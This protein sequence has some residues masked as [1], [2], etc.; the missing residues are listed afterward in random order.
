M[1][2]AGSRAILREVSLRS[3]RR[4]P[5]GRAQSPMGVTQSSPARQAAPRA[6][7][8]ASVPEDVLWAT[9]PSAPFS[10]PFELSAS[11]GRIWIAPANASDGQKQVFYFKGANWVRARQIAKPANAPK[12]TVRTIVQAGFQASGCVHRLW[13]DTVE[14]YIA[15]LV[16]H[17]FNSVRL[18]LS[19]QWILSND[20]TDG[21]C[22][23]Y[24]GWA[25]LDILDDLVIRLEQAGIFV[26]LDMHTLEVDGNQGLWCDPNSRGECTA[27]EEA[28]IRE[29]WEVL[30]A[31]YCSSPN[32]VGADLFNEPY[33]ATWGL[34]SSG[35]DWGLAAGRLGNHVLSHCS[36][37]LI[38]VEGVANNDGQ[39]RAS[40]S[41]D[42]CWCQP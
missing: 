40:A 19:V 10:T 36:R 29:A 28:P 18:P 31:R 20:E 42:F 39:C 17:R 13:D 35:T 5:A 11:E 3:A 27:N 34:G 7:R 8:A 25:T 16:E 33:S 41:H 4:S 32:V 6:I 1:Q 21:L 12:P 37:W 23:E 15:F 2:S 26:V 38:L 24:E 14:E 30:A 22:G 9:D